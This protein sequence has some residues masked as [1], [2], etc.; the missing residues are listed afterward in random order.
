[1]PRPSPTERASLL[2]KETSLPAHE[3]AEMAG[4]D[5]YEVIC[6]K[7]KSRPVHSDEKTT[8]SVSGGSPLQAAGHQRVAV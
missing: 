8:K 2:L 3:I 6:I 5:V 7:L 4:L 1:M